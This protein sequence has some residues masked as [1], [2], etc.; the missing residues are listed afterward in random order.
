MLRFLGNTLENIK[1]GA[2]TEIEST[3]IINQQD[4]YFF[5]ILLGLISTPVTL[6]NY[7]FEPGNEVECEI[8]FSFLKLRG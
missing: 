4:T 2:V 3:L 7:D 6:K 1:F 8:L 5:I